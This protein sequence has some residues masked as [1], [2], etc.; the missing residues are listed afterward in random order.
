[1]LP[2]TGANYRVSDITAQITTSAGS[3]DSFRVE[4]TPT[5]QDGDVGVFQLYLSG[6]PLGD[7]A[8]TALG[9]HYKSLEQLCALAE[10]PGT[11]GRE[12]TDLGD[13][14]GHL[15]LNLEVTEESVVFT[16]TTRPA[17]GEPLPWAPPS[18]AWMRLGVPRAE[19]I[20]TWREAEPELRR[21]VRRER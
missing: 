14:F 6:V 9:P 18:G 16:F 20:S 11:R 2:Q 5:D 19:F 1:M 21:L 17:S 13:T 7:G 4:F 12:R 15:D 8:P 10:E 3:S